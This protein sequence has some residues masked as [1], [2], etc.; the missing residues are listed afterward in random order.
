L[1]N[2]GK[3]LG[4]IFSWEE[5][6]KEKVPSLKDFHT[7]L[8]FL[9]GE[10]INNEKVV[11]ALLLGSIIR[12]DFTTTS[13]IDVLVLFRGQIFPDLKRLVCIAKRRN[14]PLQIIPIELETVRLGIHNL[15]EGDFWAHLEWAAK[16]GGMVKENPLSYIKTKRIEPRLVLEK[17]YKVILNNVSRSICELSLYEGEKKR[18]ILSKLL[19]APM[20]IIRAVIWYRYGGRE[21]PAEIEEKAI[22]LYWQIVQDDKLGQLLTEILGV[23]ND[24][25]DLLKKILK[26]KDKKPWKREYEDMLQ[27]VEAIA[28]KIFEF[29]RSNIVL[30]TSK[31]C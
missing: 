2:G 30:F 26:L 22:D 24:Y 3:K 21:N 19:E 11:G 15:A 27:K 17:T 20:H 9:V 7:V 12:G 16:N 23:K 14:V 31:K 25:S 28:P 4:R 6:I 29:V 5:I 1:Q 8:E 18:I 10:L 13:D